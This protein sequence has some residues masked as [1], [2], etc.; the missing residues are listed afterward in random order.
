L[1]RHS[2]E[3]TVVALAAVLHAIEQAGLPWDFAGWGVVA[4]P[5]FIG[6]TSVAG[7]VP[8]FIAE[9]PW[10]M[11]PHIIPHRSL[12]SVPGT[13][14]QALALHGPNFSAG[15]GPGAD[16][17][18]LIAGVTLLHGARLPG[19]WVVVTRL[20]PD[21]PCDR[22]GHAGPGTIAEAVALALTPVTQ[23]TTKR[24]ELAVTDGGQ[25]IT[26]SSKGAR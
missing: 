17:E 23:A 9:G 16:E 2:D 20:F 18:A 6:R 19:V 11:S 26:L 25:R 7:A 5:R 14:S 24:L 13:L 3:Q 1:L 4:A 15:G 22:A 12:H 21:G 10:G 8:R